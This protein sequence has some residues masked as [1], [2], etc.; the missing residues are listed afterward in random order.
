MS[1][2]DAIKIFKREPIF[3]SLFSLDFFI[4]KI[5]NNVVELGARFRSSF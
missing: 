1:E 2:N 5:C 3:F 4:P